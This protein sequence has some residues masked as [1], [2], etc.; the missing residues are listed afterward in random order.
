M[1]ISH[2]AQQHN[3]WYFALFELWTNTNRYMFE[4]NIILLWFLCSHIFALKFDSSRAFAFCV[5][6]K[7]IRAVVVGNPQTR[8]N[9][10]STNSYRVHIILS[11]RW[12]KVFESWPERQ[13]SYIHISQLWVPKHPDPQKLHHHHH[14]HNHRSSRGHTITVSLSII[15]GSCYCFGGMGAC[16]LLIESTRPIVTDELNSLFTCGCCPCVGSNTLP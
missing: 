2:H 1:F 16:V 4:S 10:L 14:L 3:P 12:L 15:S 8:K 6:V 13:Y 5:T 9:T 7:K 11:R